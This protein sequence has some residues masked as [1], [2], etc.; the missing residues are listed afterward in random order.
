MSSIA[1]ADDARQLRLKAAALVYS[2]E[3]ARSVRERQALLE[4]AH[5]KLLEIQTR[6]PSESVEIHLFLDGKRVSLSPGVV[7]AKARLAGL[8]IGNLRDVLGRE[9]SPTVADENGWTDLHYAAALNLP[10]LV[11]ELLA[12]GASVDARLRDDGAPLS[13][14]LKQSLEAL[15]LRSDFSRRGY[16]PLHMAEFHNALEAAAELLA[17]RGRE[18]AASEKETTAETEKAEEGNILGTS[19]SRA[20]SLK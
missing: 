1:L 19:S 11:K 2:A 17:T 14:S 6:Y 20:T 9:L 18:L 7:F 8:H 3:N 13:D 16:M 15:E 4:E 5:G 12:A 10:E